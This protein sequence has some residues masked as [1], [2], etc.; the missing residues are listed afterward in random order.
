MWM[1]SGPSCLNRSFSEELRVAE[2]NTWV[3][4]ILYHG[5][6]L[7]LGAS[8]S[9][10]REVVASA[11]ASLLGSVLTVCMI[12]SSHHTHDLIHDLG[13][14]VKRAT[15]RAHNEK[16]R[17][18]KERKQAQSTTHLVVREQGEDTPAESNSSTEEEKVGEVTPPPLS[19]PCVTLRSFCDI[20]SRQ[21]GIMVGEPRPKRG[22]TWTGSSVSLPQ[23]PRLMPVSSDSKGMSILP[24]LKELTH[25]SWISQVSLS[26]A[27][28]MAMMAGFSSSCPGGTKHPPKRAHFGALMWVSY[29]YAHGAA[30]PLHGFCSSSLPS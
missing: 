3:H 15:N 14:V 18:W 2:I 1:Y 17:A 16:W 12:S 6:N 22:R 10:L 7:N 4:N 13:G 29:P 19:P 30:Y 27:A 25:L 21:V 26:S 8:P 20:A 9:L 23:Q 11:R 5:A 28:A 24:T